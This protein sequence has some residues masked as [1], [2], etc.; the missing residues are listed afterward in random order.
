MNEEKITHKDAYR[1]LRQFQDWRTD[2]DFRNLTDCEY[3]TKELTEAI[4][5]I[6]DNCGYPEFRKNMA[7]CE[8]CK[9]W[10]YEGCVCHLKSCK[11]EEKK[12]ERR[13]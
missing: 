3:T 6:L 1:I 13:K 5:F 8:E 7:N 11:F 4:D 10:V 2:K 12:D 9:H